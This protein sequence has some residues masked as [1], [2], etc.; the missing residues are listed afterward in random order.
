M[1]YYEVSIKLA[2]QI[3]ISC[4]LIELAYSLRP[5]RNLQVQNPVIV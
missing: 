2:L 1:I 5:S 3:A 4:F